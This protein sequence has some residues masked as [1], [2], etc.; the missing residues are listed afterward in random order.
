MNKKDRPRFTQLMLGMADNFRDTIT[1]RG[2]DM[3]FDMLKEFSM[4]QVEFASRKILRTRKFTKMPPIAEFIEA[5]EGN[6]KTKGLEAWAVVMETL[7]MGFSPPED[8]KITEVV[9]HIGGWSWLI[10]R[11]YDELHWIEKR[12]I[13]HYESLEGKQL[14]GLIDG[15][16]T[17]LLERVN[18]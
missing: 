4:D 15:R 1:K 5:L 6:A 11:S 18:F 16:V 3:R 14:P 12:F 10:A 17:K 9:N 8:L 7:A 13:D 2:L